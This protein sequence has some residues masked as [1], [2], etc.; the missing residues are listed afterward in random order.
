[1]PTT[2]LTTRIASPLVGSPVRRPSPA[3]PPSPPAAREDATPEARA[4]PLPAQELSRVVKDLNHLVQNVQREL[5]FSID[6]HSGRT[7]IKVIDAATHQ[8]VRQ[9]PPEQIL[10][11]VEKFQQ[12]GTSGM[13]DVTA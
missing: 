11:L 6:E 2:D 10:N 9:I 5:H 3:G 1:M 12:S 7:V 8:V 4:R 13:L